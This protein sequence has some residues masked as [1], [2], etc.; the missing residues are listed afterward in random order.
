MAFC[1]PITV[2]AV[3]A[4]ANPSLGA[5]K[6]QRSADNGG[7]REY[8]S[9]EELEADF[10]SGDLHPGDLKAAV[11]SVMSDVLTKVS[12]EIKSDRRTTKAAADLK[13]FEKKHKK[14]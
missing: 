1:P 12:Q 6:V 4:I 11:T 7:D 5:L 2:A 10:S 8:S 3:F 14:K 13:A 9:K